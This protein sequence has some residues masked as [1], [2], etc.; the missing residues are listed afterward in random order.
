MPRANTLI[1]DSSDK[2]GLS[3][4]Y[5]L[6]GRVGRGNLMAYA[7]FTYKENSVLT[8]ASYKRLSALMEY[9]EMGSGYKIAMR[10]LDIR[11][12]GNVLGKEQHGH[13]DKDG[14]ELYNKLLKEQLGESTLSQ[15]LELDVKA[16]A[17]I[18]DDYIESERAR[19]EVYKEIAEI[20][21]DAD[22]ERVISSIL[23]S[24]GR[25]PKE[26][27][28]LIDIAMLKSKADKVGAVKL[29]ISLK[30]AKLYLKNLDS[31]KDGKIVKKLANYKG[32]VVLSFEENP[33][34][35][36]ITKN[37]KPEEEIKLI[38]EFLSFN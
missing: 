22:K 9:T 23:N 31:L 6:K 37:G 32:R 21:S 28:T 14:Y 19:L 2:L 38:L 1:V 12:A 7:Y 29:V 11:G 13:M 15:E 4:L 17:Y 10:D 34:L 33:I 3:T 16:D 20:T 8:D 18:P 25:I 26:V 5:Q 36:F 30:Q 24:F 27:L 35:T